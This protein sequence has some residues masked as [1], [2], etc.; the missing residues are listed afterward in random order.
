[1]VLSDPPNH[2]HLSLS[3]SCVH[4][5]EKVSGMTLLRW[6]GSAYRYND[7]LLEALLEHLDLVGPRSHGD[8]RWRFLLR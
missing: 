4:L 3:T 5:W 2:L 6:R 7:V 1:M 8:C